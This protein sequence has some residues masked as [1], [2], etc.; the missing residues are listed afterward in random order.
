MKLAIPTKKLPRQFVLFPP[1]IPA[2]PWLTGFGMRYNLGPGLIPITRHHLDAIIEDRPLA[3]TAYDGHTMWVN[4]LGLRMAGIFNGGECPPNSIIVLDQAGE[5]TGELKEHA[6]KHIEAVLPVP[7]RATR[8]RLLK[9]GTKIASQM[10]LTSIHNMDGDDEQAGLYAEL[11]QSGDLT[12][13]VYIPYSIRV[14]TPFEAI[15]EQAFL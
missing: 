11:E 7:D 3:I 6:S 14:D 9:K 10:G 4:T 8:L 15:Q 13:R 1:K 12:V 2:V 5:A